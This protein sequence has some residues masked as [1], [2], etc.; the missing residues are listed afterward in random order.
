MKQT[1]RQTRRGFTLIELMVVIVIVAALV[2][3][4]FVVGKRAIR[5][6]RTAAELSNLR[7]AA[8]AV[9]AYS[10]DIGYFPAGYNWTSGKSW[11]TATLEYT[12]G[13]GGGSIQGDTFRSPVLN[14]KV[15]PGADWTVTHFGGNP[16]VFAD[17][18]PPDRNTGEAAPKW[19][20]TQNRLMRPAEQFLLCSMPP[21]GEDA[22]YKSAHAI[23]W[24]M[25]NMAG[26]GFPADGTVPKSNRNLAQKP[27]KLPDGLADEQ[28]YNDLPDFFRFGD[29]KGMF[30]FADGHVERMAPGD[31]KQKHL[32]I[33]Y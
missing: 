2:A 10:T 19:R 20:V 5:A 24:A 11:A 7:Q 1:H 12:L 13:E 9:S 4:S 28:Q 30:V 6:S 29:G 18:G 8:L 16:Y 3:I 33:S 21:A 25:R 32:A 27:L 17:S 26:G 15:D 23:A 31:L 22:Q 14:V